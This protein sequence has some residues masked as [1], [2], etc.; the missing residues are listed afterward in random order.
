VKKDIQEFSVLIASLAIG[1]IVAIAAA[2]VGLGIFFK[3]VKWFI[4]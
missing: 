1:M 2:G 4:Q 3:I